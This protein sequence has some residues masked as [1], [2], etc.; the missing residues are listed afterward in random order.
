MPVPTPSPSEYNT[1]SQSDYALLDLNQNE[2]GG[3][4]LTVILGFDGLADNLS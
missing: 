3:R 1:P 4:E 2:L